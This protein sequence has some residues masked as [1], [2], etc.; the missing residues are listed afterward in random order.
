MA[1]GIREDP[2]IYAEFLERELRKTSTSI[3]R[4]KLNLDEEYGPSFQTIVC[5][6]V[7]LCMK[8]KWPLKALGSPSAAKVLDHV[9]KQALPNIE[10]EV[11][12][13]FVPHGIAELPARSLAVYKIKGAKES[14]VLTFRA[15]GC[16]SDWATDVMLISQVRNFD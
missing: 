3:A 2:G 15:T 14:Y 5:C 4:H 13:Q 16:L 10:E 9:Y 7:L 12:E 11:T 8:N 6:N 1:H